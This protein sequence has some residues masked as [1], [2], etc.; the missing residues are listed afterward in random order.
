MA[1]ADEDPPLELAVTAAVADT[2]A[3]LADQVKTAHNL[4]LKKATAKYRFNQIAGFHM[5]AGFKA[6]IRA[7]LLEKEA[8]LT[9]L[10]A[11]KIEAL[12][13]EQ[14]E[15]EK[16]KPSSVFKEPTKSS[17]S[18][19]VHSINENYTPTSQEEVDAINN[20]WKTIQ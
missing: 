3:A 16:N 9:T 11:I 7:S 17:S 19:G 4:A 15:M 13:I 2:F 12:K 14:K 1:L 20:Q 10:D 5:M 6:S 8:E 18:N